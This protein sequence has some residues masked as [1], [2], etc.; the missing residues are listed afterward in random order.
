M[1][2]SRLLSFCLLHGDPG[3]VPDLSLPLTFTFYGGLHCISAFRMG[4]TYQVY[5][6]L[7]VIVNHDT[8]AH[9][10]YFVIVLDRSLG[11]WASLEPQALADGVGEVGPW[12]L[13]WGRVSVLSGQTAERS[14]GCC[15]H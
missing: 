10:C 7:H 11:S 12:S 4:D 1:P 8:L 3:Q 9:F 2:N 5:E 13:R 6:K 14:L 15:P